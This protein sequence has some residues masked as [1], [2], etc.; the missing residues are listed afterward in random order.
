MRDPSVMPLVFDVGNS[1][2]NG[3]TIV[4]VQEKK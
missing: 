3:A 1:V 2:G 4:N